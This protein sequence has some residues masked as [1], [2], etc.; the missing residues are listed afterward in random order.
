MK[1]KENIPSEKFDFVER[2]G[3]P[4]RV[5]VHTKNAIYINVSTLEAL[6]DILHSCPGADVEDGGK[7][8]EFIIDDGSHKNFYKVRRFRVVG[9]DYRKLKSSK[10]NKR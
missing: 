3:N 2:F 7:D 1:K 6:F 10:K 4:F 8:C 9:E 5:S